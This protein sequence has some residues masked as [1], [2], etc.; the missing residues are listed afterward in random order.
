MPW[1]PALCAGATACAGGS[2]LRPSTGRVVGRASG[3]GQWGDARVGAARRPWR[4]EQG[5]GGAGA[6]CRQG[7]AERS[8]ARESGVPGACTRTGARVGT[9]RGRCSRRAAGGRGAGRLRRARVG[10]CSGR[11][12]SARGAGGARA[13]P[14][15]CVAGAGSKVAFP[16]GGRGRVEQGAGRA[17][18]RARQR[19]K[20]EERGRGKEREKEKKKRKWKKR[21]GGRKRGGERWIRAGITALIAEPVGHAWR[22]GARER[23][24]QVEGK[25]GAGYGCRVFGESGDPAEQGGFRKTGVRV[26]R[27]DLELNDEAKILAHDLF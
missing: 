24:A 22:P 27:R 6:A 20:E 3:A 26:S 5:V 2:E 16:G 12:G 1:S 7:Q 14:A 13:G 21:N 17:G 25:Q 8:G 11:A 15:C 10:T 19:R 9:A 4:A 23:D 18:S